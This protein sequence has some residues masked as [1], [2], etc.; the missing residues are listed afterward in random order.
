MAVR[1]NRRLVKY[2]VAIASV[3]TVLAI[4]SLWVQRQ[5]LNTNDWV[6]TSGKLLQNKDIQ[7]A[8][9]NYAVDQFY[10]TVNVSDQL[11]A[12]LPPDFQGLSG[13]A[14]TGLQQ[15]AQDGVPKILDTSRFQG[16]WQDANRVAHENLV[17]IV[18]GNSAVIH[19]VNG[20]VYLN[21]RPLIVSVANSVGIGGDVASK[22]PSDI[23]RIRILRSEDLG[24]AQDVIRAI[25]GFAVVSSLLVLI[26][27]G[28]AIYLSRGYRWVTL[29]GIGIGLV[30]AG[31]VTMILR[32]VI[33]TVVVNQL[34]AD[35]VKDAGNAAWSI[36]TSLWFSIAATV[37]VYGGAF[38]VA[39]W[40]GS[41]SRSARGTRR[42][43][44]PILREQV[45][46]VAGVFGSVAFIYLLLGVGSTRTE[47]TRLFLIVLA[48]IGLVY[49]RRQSMAEFPQAQMP[50][51]Q[52]GMREG[53]QSVRAWAGRRG[54][55]PEAPEDTRLDRLERL[56]SLHER[57]ILDDAEF[58]AEKARVLSM[59]D[60]DGAEPATQ[61]LAPPPQPPEPE[62]EKGG[63]IGRFVSTVTQRRR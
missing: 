35:P 46:A 51:V 37:V 56:G 25:R 49:L 15:L 14:A 53:M 36:G 8:L 60:G 59:A 58:A 1:P 12:A 16:L 38:L 2:L 24:L 42:F 43:L 54:P 18:E 31:L 40:L 27:F 21:V 48:G 7:G 23:G 17:A 4:F 29:F 62:P 34:A 55:R 6:E 52:A 63:A 28:I 33:G 22:I 44:T 10:A 41:P 39:G 45:P 47:L 19:N 30:L 13:P 26:L 61:P 11:K 5:L 57:G 32:E 3:L 50:D 20:T 9:G